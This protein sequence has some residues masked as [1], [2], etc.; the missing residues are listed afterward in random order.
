[1]ATET[2]DPVGDAAPERSILEGTAEG[3]LFEDGL[4]GGRIVVLPFAIAGRGIPA[5]RAERPPAM[6]S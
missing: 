5:M 6:Q 2:T 3:V 4:G 1:M